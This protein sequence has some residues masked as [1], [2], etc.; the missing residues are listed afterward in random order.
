MHVPRRVLVTGAGG[1]VGSHLCEALLATGCTVIGLEGFVRTSYDPQIKRRNLRRCL[2]HPAFTLVEADLRYDT[3]EPHLQGVDTVVNQ[4]AMP[5][6]A[7]SW[8]EF[9]AYAG[10]NLLALQRLVE[11][12]RTSGVRRFVQA[13]TSSV[14]GTHAVGDETM[15]TQPISPYGVTKLAAEQ[16]LL[17]HVGAYGFPAVILR[18]FS[19][20]GPRQ[21]PDMAYQIFI[22][23]LCAG[24]PITIC[25]DG[26]QSRSNTYVAD[27]VR[28]TIDAIGGA[29]VGEAYNIGGGV[30]L[31]LNEAVGIIGEAMGVAPQTIHEPPRPG[32]Q[33][34]TAADVSKARDTFGYR[35][36]VTP[37]VGLATQ[38]AHILD[39]HSWS[40]R[41]L[42][43]IPAPV[44]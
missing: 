22:E 1:F 41:K 35:P 20:Y 14:Y 38:V 31:T 36:H 44:S 16:L 6:L 2:A 43:R 19:I 23:A 28:G 9:D 7:R 5:G 33:R 26:L 3:L 13:S 25:G 32:D 29:Q 37:E 39:D 10:C 40:I 18:Y 42:D 4:A 17:A 21:R 24:R 11:A 12:A 8:T 30:A 34:H 27:C 15:P